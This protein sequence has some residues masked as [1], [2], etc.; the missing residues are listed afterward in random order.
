[1]TNSS[2]HSVSSDSLLAW[3]ASSTPGG[4][5]RRPRERGSGIAD[6]KAVYPFVPDM[7]RYYLGEQPSGQCA[8]LPDD[9]A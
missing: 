2:I 7:I 5:E 9:Q 3:P 8:N 1:M 6:D 4:R